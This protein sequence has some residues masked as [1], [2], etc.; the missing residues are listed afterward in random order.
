MT[1]LPMYSTV[2]DGE[3]IVEPARQGDEP[4]GDPRGHSFTNGHG[5]AMAMKTD[6]RLVYNTDS[7]APGDFTPWKTALRVIR[8]AGL[9]G[10]DAARVQRNAREVL[11][12]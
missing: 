5:A 2:G 11:G 8:G 7:H 6:A 12:R 10:R 1:D 9:T 4:G 3:T